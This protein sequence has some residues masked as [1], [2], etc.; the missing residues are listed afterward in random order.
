MIGLGLVSAVFC[1]FHLTVPTLEIQG[2]PVSLSGVGEQGRPHFKVDVK[3]A[4]WKRKCHYKIYII[5]V[6]DT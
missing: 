4:L 1:L 3:A 2:Q 6:S 5:C